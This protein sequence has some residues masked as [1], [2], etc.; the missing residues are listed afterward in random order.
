MFV[1]TR[2][3]LALASV[4][5]AAGCAASTEDGASA[6]SDSNLTQ[7]V[8]AQAAG[9]SGAFTTDSGAIKGLVLGA[10]GHSFVADIATNVQCITA[11][12]PTSEH[13]V[14]TFTSTATTITL[15]SSSASDLVADQL[16]TYSY[17]IANGTLSL[18]RGESAARNESSLEKSYSYCSVPTDCDIQALEH[19]HCP[20][21][22]TCS[23]SNSCDFACAK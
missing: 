11:P 15:T 3:V 4:L 14:G 10:T 17:K 12:C 9:L 5:F 7:Q 20:G 21:S 19:A 22:W 8:G 13:V 23:T 18:I 16:G 1:S 2:T 6:A